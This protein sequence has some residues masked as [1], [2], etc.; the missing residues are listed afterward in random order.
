MLHQTPPRRL[1]NAL[2]AL[3]VSLALLER[4]LWNPRWPTPPASAPRPSRRLWTVACAAPPS[5]LLSAGARHSRPW[6][7]APRATRACGP[8]SEDGRRAA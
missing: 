3:T 1:Q 7:R 8:E 2:A 6:A 5:W 4:E